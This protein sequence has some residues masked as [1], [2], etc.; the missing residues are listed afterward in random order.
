MRFRGK[1]IYFTHD[2]LTIRRRSGTILVIDSYEIVAISDGK[3]RLERRYRALDLFGK[4]FKKRL[5]LSF[6]SPSVVVLWADYALPV[7]KTHV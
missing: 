2:D 5:P 4:H 6:A 3:T 1:P 7:Q